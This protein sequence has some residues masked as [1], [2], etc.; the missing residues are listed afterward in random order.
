MGMGSNCTYADE[1]IFGLI[2]LGYLCGQDRLTHFEALSHDAIIQQ[3]LGLEGPVD[4]NTLAPRAKKAGYK[5]S[6]Q[7]GRVQGP[8]GR[9]GPFGGHYRNSMTMIRA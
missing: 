1:Q 6:V 3:L 8:A 7:L 4:E 2:V 9:A 5:Q